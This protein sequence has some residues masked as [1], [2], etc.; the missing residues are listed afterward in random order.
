M[1]TSCGIIDG[2]YLRRLFFRSFPSAFQIQSEDDTSDYNNSAYNRNC[3]SENGNGVKHCYGNLRSETVKISV[4][5]HFFR[6]DGGEYS[7]QAKERARR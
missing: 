5:D 7:N 3:R 4:G 1:W 6:D 2:K